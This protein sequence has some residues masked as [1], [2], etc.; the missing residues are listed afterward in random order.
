MRRLRNVAAMPRV[1]PYAR[2]D[3]AAVLEICVLAFAPACESLERRRGVD[4]GW[5][6]AMERYLRSLTRPSR[7]RGLLVAEVRT[8]V[9]GFVHYDIDPE[10]RSGSVGV[11]AVHPARQGRGIGS[12]LFR[13]V[14]DA[15]RAQGLECATAD[16]STEASQAPLRRAYEKA[17]FVARPAVH[18][19]VNLDDSIPACLGDVPTTRDQG[20]S[21]RGA[22][23]SGAGRGR[24]D[25]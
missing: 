1:R 19:V 4:L 14:I 21:R 2:K 3:W 10:T 11:S 20:R 13:R 16:A 15:M 24:A 8:T 25:D 9:V 17:G 6:A 22:A 7:T 12:L 5:K 23:A 18:Y